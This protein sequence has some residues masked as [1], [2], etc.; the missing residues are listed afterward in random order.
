VLAGCVPLHIEAASIHSRWEAGKSNDF[1][2]KVLF[3][4]RPHPAEPERKWE[5]L[6]KDD[7]PRTWFWTDASRKEENTT[8]GIVR[9]EAGE[10]VERRGASAPGWLPDTYGGA[11][12][13]G[14]RD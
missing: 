2:R 3:A 14:V 12:C 1:E 13:A 5:E 10:I 9:N 6:A 4:E 7:T 8:V 11:V